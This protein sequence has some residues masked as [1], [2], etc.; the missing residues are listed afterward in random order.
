MQACP[1][2][3]PWPA[4]M[5]IEPAVG[6]LVVGAVP[7]AAGC[8][9]RRSG[10]RGGGRARRPT[11]RRDW[12]RQRGAAS[13]PGPLA[14]W[15]RRWVIGTLAIASTVAALPALLIFSN[16]MR[17]EWDFVSA[18]FL[19]A[20][21]ASWWALRACPLAR[22]RIAVSVL[23]G[24]ARVGVDCRGG[25]AGLR[26]LLRQLHAPQPDLMTHM[27]QMFDVCRQH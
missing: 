2:W 20:T 4:D 10:W 16:S 24:G 11:S 1:A 25:P 9:R 26:R 15:T 3:V 7:L 17:Y 18:L 23:V 12:R 27:K 14:P 21:L 22:G 19:A 5:R 6:V 8:R 13:T